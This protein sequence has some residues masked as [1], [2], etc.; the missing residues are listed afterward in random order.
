MKN[1]ILATA[2]LLTAVS[3]LSADCC[4]G[5]GRL[6]VRGRIEARHAARATTVSTVQTT[7]TT[8]TVV[9]SCPNGQCPIPQGKTAP[10]IVT[11]A[12]KPPVDKMK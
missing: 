10:Q 11:P 12:P 4:N 5:T 2:L 7:T 9:G 6:G 8:K 1:L 3:D